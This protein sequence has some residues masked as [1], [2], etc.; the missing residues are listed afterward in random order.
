M[1]P[2]RLVNATGAGDSMVAGFLAKVDEGADYDRALRFA[3]ACGSAT[4]SSKGLAKR[5]TID[6]LAALLDEVMDGKAGEKA[7]ARAKAGA[8]KT[9]G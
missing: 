3:S 9:E 2:I 4:A 7:S 6:R 1:P 8:K 5:E